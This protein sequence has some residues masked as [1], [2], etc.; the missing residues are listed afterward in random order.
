M[1][2]NEQIISFLA[3]DYSDEIGVNLCHA[4]ALTVFSSQGTTVDGNTFTLY[5]GRMAQREAYVALSRHK[6]E[7]HVYVNEAEI[8]ERVRSYED[9]IELSD[10]LRQSALA[11]LMKQDRHVSLAIEHLEK[12]QPKLQTQEASLTL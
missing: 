2:D 11:E 5:S 1:L 7:S 3:S 10:K 4:Y 8:N 12:Q 6:D 9:G